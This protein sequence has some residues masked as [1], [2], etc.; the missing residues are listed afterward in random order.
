M[1]SVAWNVFFYNP[2]RNIKTIL[3]LRAVKKVLGLAC[4]LQFD[5]S[6]YSF[7]T[8]SES[9]LSWS[10]PFV[11]PFQS[12]LAILGTLHFHINFKINQFQQKRL[13]DFQLV[14][15]WFWGCID[16]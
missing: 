10:F 11:L 14:F 3:N 7:I 15:V 1:S 16:S 5:N 8:H 9:R 6:C 4:R 12:V 2:I 13:L